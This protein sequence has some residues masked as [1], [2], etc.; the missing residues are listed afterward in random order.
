MACRS[1]TPCTAGIVGSSRGGTLPLL[2]AEPL[3]VPS[4]CWY[5]NQWYWS[6]VSGLREQQR[7]MAA[8]VAVSPSPFVLR[9]R[10]LA[11]PWPTPLRCRVHRSVLRVLSAFECVELAFWCRFLFARSFLHSVPRT[12]C[13]A[14]A[15]DLPSSPP[16]RS[17]PQVAQVVR[18]STLASLRDD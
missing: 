5:N 13:C 4:R 1:A 17:R 3:P 18:F 2:S 15:L 9:A 14:V 6:V 16:E 10:C 7:F 8:P 11:E 12:S